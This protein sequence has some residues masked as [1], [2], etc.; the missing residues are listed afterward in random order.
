M[1]VRT[2]LI[3]VASFI[4]LGTPATAAQNLWELPLRWQL[5]TEQ[6]CELRY[7]TNLRTDRIDRQQFVAGRAH[8]ADGRAFEVIRLHGLQPFA[9]RQCLVEAEA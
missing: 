7:F 3:A 9:V 1:C 6:R 4:A 5:Q 2:I 8:C